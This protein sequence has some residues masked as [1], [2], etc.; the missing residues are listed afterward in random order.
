MK[1]IVCDID[2]VICHNHFIPVINKYLGTR[3]KESDFDEV[4]FEKVLFPDDESRRKFNNFYVSVDSYEGVRLMDHAYEVL[5]KLNK[6]HRLILLT[7]CCHYEMPVEFGRQFTD[8]WKFISEKLP[9]LP[10]ENIIFAT[11]K[12]LIKGDVIIDDRLYNMTGDYKH[13][14][15]YTTFHNKKVTDAERVVGN[16]VDGGRS[17]GV[18]V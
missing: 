7:N 4:Q 16:D 13:K 5:K 3:Y 12:D 15:M 6:K 10:L 11:Q 14:L 17:K 2:D 8:K 18:Y 9:F 1:T